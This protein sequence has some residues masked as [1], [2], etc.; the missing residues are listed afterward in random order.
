[1]KWALGSASSILFIV[2]V[3]VV[4]VFTCELGVAAFLW[5]EELEIG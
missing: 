2:V 5:V 4:V 3:V 1:M